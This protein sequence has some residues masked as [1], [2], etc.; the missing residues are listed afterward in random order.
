[1]KGIERKLDKIKNPISAVKGIERK[2]DERKTPA[3]KVL[4]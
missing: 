1:V 3:V 4:N 2:A